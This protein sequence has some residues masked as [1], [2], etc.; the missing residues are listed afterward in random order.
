MQQDNQ[1]LRDVVRQTVIDFA[2][3]NG[4]DLI[5]FAA[6]GTWDEVGEVPPDFRP[7]AIWK[8]TNTVI[9]LGLGMLLPVIETTPSIVH[10]E[11][12]RTCNR[13]LDRLAFNL[14]RFLNREG[15]A[16][17]FFPR[18]AYGDIKLLVEKPL[19]AFSH[20]MAAKYAGLG[21]IG[22]SHNLLTREF[23]PRVRFVSVFTSAMIE[24]GKVLDDEL[25]IKCLACVECCPVGAIAPTEDGVVGE[26]AKSACARRHV[27]LTSERRYPCGICLKVC[28]VGE[29]RKLYTGSASL[30]KYREEARA[31]A[32]DPD[33]PDYRA[34]EHIRRY[35]SRPS[36]TEEAKHD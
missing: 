2:Q 24:P 33:H 29:D 26:L 19:A 25:C 36:S 22:L 12:Y 13:E 28:P 8:E 16:S 21:T 30:A 15:F 32:L 1:Q 31:L 14:A 9:V 20:V 10:T 18:D 17:T 7:R 5:G 34:W 35:G 3:D 27:E 11:M 4:V 23:G 6:P